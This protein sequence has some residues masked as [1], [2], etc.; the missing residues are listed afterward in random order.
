MLTTVLPDGRVQDTEREN[1]PLRRSRCI[2]AATIV[3]ASLAGLAGIDPAAWARRMLS[4]SGSRWS[5]ARRDQH[6]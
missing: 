2:D 3:S 4:D 6:I 5:R 1:A